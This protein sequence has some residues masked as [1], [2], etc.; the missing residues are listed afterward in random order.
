MVEWSVL[1]EDKKKSVVQWAK[2][3]PLNVTV[4]S[5]SRYRSPL[6]AT[7]LTHQARGCF[8]LPHLP[9]CLQDCHYLQ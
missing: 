1:Q 5:D 7:S 6:I 4:T 9:R 8:P 2:H 3:A